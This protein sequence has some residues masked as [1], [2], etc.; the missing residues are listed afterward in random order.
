MLGWLMRSFARAARQRP[1]LDFVVYSRAGCH[2]CDEAWDQLNQ[3]Q[4]QY[5]FPLKKV[6]VD[7]DPH[8][9]AQHGN[10]VPVI[11]VNGKVRF[12]GRVNAV[13]LQRLL[14]GKAV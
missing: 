11:T 7:T 1:D 10:C 14:E 8:L 9:L 2:L 4:R 5:A 13:L 12:R 3:A 6:D